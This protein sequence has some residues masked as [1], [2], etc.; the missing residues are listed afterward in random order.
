[1][2]QIIKIHL[3]FVYLR[4]RNYDVDITAVLNAQVKWICFAT[5]RHILWK[6]FGQFD[7][8]PQLMVSLFFITLCLSIF[9]T[10]FQS[11]D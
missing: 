7:H 6:C 9:L 2:C 3:I 1:M 10:S 8:L 4:K 11:N 5:K